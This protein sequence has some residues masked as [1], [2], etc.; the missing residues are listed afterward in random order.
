ML[1]KPHQAPIRTIAPALLPVSL[2]EVKAKLDVI[3]DNSQD[4][5]IRDLVVQAVD[6]VEHDSLRMLMPQTW[7]LTLD[8]FPCDAIELRRLPVTTLSHVKYITGGVLTT[9]ATTEYETDLI[10]EPCRV[11]PVDGAVWPETDCT[12]NAVTVTWVAG[13]ANAAGVPPRAKNAV[14]VAA[15]QLYFGC[16]EMGPGY[17]SLIERLRWG[18]LV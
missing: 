14:L 15:R 8:E 7:T 18:G 12:V 2:D 13:Y 16:S 11:R 9:L 6:M 17:W 3:D 4:K 5:E 1:L 10:S